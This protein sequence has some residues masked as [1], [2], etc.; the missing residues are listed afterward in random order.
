MSS[1]RN[2]TWITL[3]GAFVGFVIGLILAAAIS[4]IPPSW[5]QQIYPTISS[6]ADP[7]VELIGVDN[8]AGLLY[9]RSRSQ[10]IYQCHVTWSD[11]PTTEVCTE[12]EPNIA[13][14]LGDSAP[15]KGFI[16]PTPRPPG[17]VLASLQA[18]PCSDDANI[19]VDYIILNDNSIW[20]S[21]QSTGGAG[22][23]IAALFTMVC[24]TVGTILGLVIGF[25]ISRIAHRNHN[26]RHQR[27]SA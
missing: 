6:Q 11:E 26:K 8:Q 10:K 27:E 24:A 1:T 7:A 9:V 21:T 16:F 13:A 3:L 18:H 12:T 20:R 15:C 4:N 22:E 5:E 23:A 2:Y 25:V 14:K 19:Q 17:T